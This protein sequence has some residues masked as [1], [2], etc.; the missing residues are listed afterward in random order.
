MK[1][2]DMKK[3]LVKLMYI[4]MR[5]NKKGEANFLGAAEIHSHIRPAVGTTYSCKGVKI[6]G[7]DYITS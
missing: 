5:Y 2:L 4:D 6:K 3:D 1:K 7:T